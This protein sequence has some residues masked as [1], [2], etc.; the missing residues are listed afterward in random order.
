MRQLYPVL[1]AISLVACASESASNA[2]DPVGTSS[3]APVPPPTSPG[4]AAVPV[5]TSGGIAPPSQEQPGELIMG[6]PEL[7]A[8]AAASAQKPVECA[9]VAEEATEVTL[10][11]D[12]IIVID[13]S[14][15]MSEEITEVQARINGD[16]AQVM[17]ASG[18]D[19]RVI[20]VAR[21][22]DVNTSVGQSDHPVCIGAPLGA[23]TCATSSTEP[24]TN[25][26]PVFFHY[27]ADVGS[28]EP[29][30]DL[31][32]GF[33][34]PDE[35]GA[36][37]GDRA[38]PWTML[39]PSGYSEYLREDAFKHFLVITDDNSEC[40]VTVGASAASADAGPP[41]GN[42]TYGFDDQ[43]QVQSG[44]SAAQDFDE[45]L[46]A[47]S[48]AQFG[49]AQE[50]KYRWHS[51][52]GMAEKPTPDGGTPEPW[53]PNE[54][55]STENCGAD[56]TDGVGTGFQQLSVMTGG[57]RYPSCRTENFN[58]VFNAIAEGIV[59][60]AKLSC[61]WA[62]PEA[63]DG[64][65][66]DKTLVNV[67]FTTG[68]GAAEVVPKADSLEACAG[69]PGWY[70]DNEESPTVIRAC[71]TSCDRFQAEASGQVSIVFGC[72]TVTRIAR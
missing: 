42:T 4:S 54:P 35:I 67:E 65:V 48:P 11:V 5:D 47:L 27:S 41:M 55:I 57:L 25:N 63:P 21:Y 12:I 44:L 68:V 43:D 51:I 39:F 61:E 52:V 53:L 66:F 13:N 6:N 40:Q 62:I 10:P 29:W 32:E 72:E 9:G 23:T 56:I 14:S 2:D 8:S 26:P 70:F 22:G 64:K 31:L 1:A 17:A 15:S 46:L 30:C 38:T 71:P 37:N 7:E 24:L 60:G 34:S 28:R 3:P 59:E 45:A 19:Y 50:R 33:S 18:L 36:T 49:T 20:L 58:A 69:M 16:F